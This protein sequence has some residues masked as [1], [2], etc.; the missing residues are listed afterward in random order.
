MSPTISPFG[1]LAR[2]CP[3][4]SIVADGSRQIK[5]LDLYMQRCMNAIMYGTHPRRARNTGASLVSSSTIPATEHMSGT[6]AYPSTTQ[7][8]VYQEQLTI[9]F[10]VPKFYAP[11]GGKSTSQLYTRN[12]Q[13]CTMSFGF[14]DIANLQTTGVGAT[15]TY[16]N[17]SFSIVPI[18]VEDRNATLANGSFDYNE[19][20]IRRSY[21]SAQN[22][23]QILLS[24]GN[25]I[26]GLAIMAQN[27]DSALS[28]NDNV[29]TNIN[30]YTNGVNPIAIE[31]FQSLSNDNK[32]K[33]GIGDDQYAS[34]LRPL[35]GFA[36][37]SFVKNGDV[38]SGLPT[39]LADGVS[40]CEL[41]ISTNPSSGLNAITLTNSIIVSVLQQQLVPVPVKG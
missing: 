39:A 4:F 3:N 21:S 20:V 37:L 34:S 13:S 29:L 5:I 28:L 31:T 9:D 26:L 22:N 7:D 40:T 30:M 15:V 14:G 27:G 17:V 10:E 24:A 12:L 11:N 35:T 32:L 38:R 8:I 16:S 18:I 23:A 19:F 41:Q 6:I 1:A 2:I 25:K 33:S 36:H